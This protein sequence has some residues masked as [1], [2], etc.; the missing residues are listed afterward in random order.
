[1]S[2]NVYKVRKLG[3][4][5]LYAAWPKF[6]LPNVIDDLNK[7]SEI[8]YNFGTPMINYTI[9][10]AWLDLCDEESFYVKIG[11]NDT[12]G[13]YGYPNDASTF[14][15]SYYS[16]SV[17]K[18][19]LFRFKVGD[20]MK[21]ADKQLG[22]HGYKCKEINRDCAVYQRR[23]V[24]IRIYMQKT[25]D[26]YNKREYIRNGV[27]SGYTVELKKRINI[28]KVINRIMKNITSNT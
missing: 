3:R 22:K 25:Q 27:V 21:K 13:F 20:S 17:P 6:I 19:S 28:I 18:R 7:N 26:C 5:I 11:E 23:Q 10:I 9:D 4:I 12:Y 8:L 2:S 14:K 16:T 15:F 24:T 1:M